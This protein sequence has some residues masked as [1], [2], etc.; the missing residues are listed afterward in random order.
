MTR[1]G[2]QGHKKKNIDNNAVSCVIGGTLNT[3]FIEGEVL[4]KNGTKKDL[5]CKSKT[6]DVFL[7]NNKWV[8]NEDGSRTSGL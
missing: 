2:S 7:G 8:H 1:V 5:I 4:F 3:S 6:V